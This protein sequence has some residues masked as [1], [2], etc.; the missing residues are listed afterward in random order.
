V[1]RYV[2][3]IA[4]YTAASGVALACDVGILIALIQ[5]LDLHYLVASAVSFTAGACVAYVLSVRFAF[6]YRRIGSQPIELASFVGIGAI[7]LGLNAGAMYV[8]VEWGG[9][10]YLVAKAVAS[11]LTFVF[12]YTARRL[13]LFT[14]PR[15]TT[16]AR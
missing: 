11:I 10:H 6:A 15:T 9:Q 4:A 5:T 3:E 12:N 8:A 1:K 7:G 14:P 13:F 16:H 2:R